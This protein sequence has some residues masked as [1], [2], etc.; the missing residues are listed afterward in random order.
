MMACT[1]PAAIESDSPFRISLPSTATYRFLISSITGSEPLPPHLA[2]EI[3]VR[4]TRHTLV[5]QDRVNSALGAGRRLSTVCP[6]NYLRRGKRLFA[7]KAYAAR[8]FFDSST[9]E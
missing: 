4:S 8:T 6:F 7:T 9:V 3:L 1:S 5:R 2:Q